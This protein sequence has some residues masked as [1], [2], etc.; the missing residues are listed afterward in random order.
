MTRQRRRRLASRT[1]GL[2][3]R[4]RWSGCGA[5]RGSFCMCMSRF[6]A[7]QPIQGGGTW[8]PHLTSSSSLSDTSSLSLDSR[9]RAWQDTV[10]CERRNLIG[11]AHS[12]P[13][14]RRLRTF[15]RLSAAMR[16]NS[17]ACCAFCAAWTRITARSVWPHPSHFHGRQC[18]NRSRT[19]IA[20]LQGHAVSSSSAYLCLCN[21]LCA[22]PYASWQT[23]D[24]T[25]I[26]SGGFTSSGKPR[27]DGRLSL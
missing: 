27:G 17:A 23:L 26:A 7:H 6:A 16:F 8:V 20:Q 3:L 13:L 25:V 5:H 10:P 12:S 22:Q 24:G 15:R 4:T 21:V 1:R 2:A 19:L 11:C 9:L 14:T 18:E